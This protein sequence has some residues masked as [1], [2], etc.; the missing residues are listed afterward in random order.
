MHDLRDDFEAFHRPEQ[1]SA[2]TR[3]IYGALA[4]ALM[5][6]PVLAAAQ[7]AAAGAAS[8]ATG[9]S[10]S[11]T[12][13]P[14]LQ[15]VVVTATRR[16]EAI[17]KVPMSITALTQSNMDIRGIKDITDVARFTPGVYIDNSGT[18]NIS[19]RGI[20]STGGAGTTG[21]YIDDTPIQMRALAFNP[22]EA[23]PQAFDLDRVEVLRGPQGT[24]F[25][26]GSE[27][28]TVRYITT[29]PSLTQ[30]SMYSRD[31]VSDTQGGAPSYEAGIAAGTPVIPGTLGV[32]ATVWYRRD[33]GYIDLI[34]PVTLNTIDSNANYSESALVRLDAIWAI[35]DTW[36]VRPGFYYQ[37]RESNNTDDYWPLY[38]NPGN[39]SFVSADPD[40]RV[41]PDR[42]YLP[43]VQVTGDFGKVQLIE[44]TSYYHRNDITGYEGTI[45]NLGFYQSAAVFGSVAD[46]LPLLIDGDGIHLPDGATNYRSPASINNNQRNFNEEVRLQSSDPDSALTW[47]TGLF[48]ADDRQ[49]YLEQIHDPDLNELTEAYL[50]E[51]YTDVFCNF[52][53][54][55]DACTTP[56]Q[57]IT[58]DPRFPNDS[59][60]LQTYSK[61]T[62]V[63]WYG[64]ATYAFTK[65]WQLTLGARESRMQ[66]TFNT[67]TGGQQ[68]FLT[69]QT[70]SGGKTETAFTPKASLSYQYDDND[71]YYATYAKGFRPGGANN[72]V[73]YA[74]CATDF[75]SF[76]IN[77]APQ[78][79][80][81]DSVNSYEVGAK[82]NFSGRVQIATSV[83]YIKWNNI[84]QTVVPP[85]CQISFI[86][87]LG[88]AVAKGA[89][90]DV[91]IALVGNLTAEI[92]AGYTDARYTEDARFSATELTPIVSNGDAVTGQSGQPGPPVTASIGL[93][94]GFELFQHDSFV[95]FDEEFEGRAKW[96]S[97]QQDSNTQQYDP[98]DYVLS[99]TSYMSLR[100]GMRFGA[101]RF[102]GFVDN[103]ANTHTVTNYE[104]SIDPGLCTPATLACES[105][106]RLQ[107]QWTFPPRTFGVTAIYRY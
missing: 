45:Y 106:T 94:Y 41:R 2:R 77:A 62:Q 23:L 86:A 82:N 78:T 12:T 88:Q 105:Q 64:Q 90:I 11:A 15:E 70:G 43:S 39:N 24:L 32:R 34:N 38:S 60:F 40:Q 31:E 71:L 80:S 22:D 83:Y 28:G 14:A 69:P 65:Q 100:T 75:Q 95:R 85:I 59:Y 30:T 35:N 46:G 73:P 44:D 98:A 58:Y 26:A 5:A 21:I 33:G 42:F 84:Q 104:W 66:Y 56:Y 9:S 76:G 101:W 48:F 52:D 1:G 3:L 103:L 7:N 63:A 19:I 96:P 92:T 107:D 36:H 17:S 79:F 97:P 81:S 102:E 13:G 20:A 51:P 54:T 49:S 74:A 16:A 89:D 29:A 91:N 4:C 6:A 57:P 93:Q 18:A 55:L 10:A 61:D 50:G 87:N 72:P 37:S 99:S 8:G 67:L 53:A 25:G 68:L 27:G 47:T